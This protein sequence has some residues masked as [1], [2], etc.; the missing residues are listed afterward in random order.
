MEEIGK[1]GGEKGGE[2]ALIE[3]GRKRHFLSDDYLLL[4]FFYSM[5][6]VVVKHTVSM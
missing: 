1:E 3:G 5:Q 2:R 6:T 4:C